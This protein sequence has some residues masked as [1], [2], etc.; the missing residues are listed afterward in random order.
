MVLEVDREE[1]TVAGRESESSS[2]DASLSSC[3]YSVILLDYR[4]SYIQQQVK[5]K[6]KAE[7]E[8]EA[9]AKIEAKSK[10]IERDE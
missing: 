1:F 4:D 6:P 5:A 10:D 7:A 3:G 9:E 2:P 8:I